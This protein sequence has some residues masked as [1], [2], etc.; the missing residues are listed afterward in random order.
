MAAPALRSHGAARPLRGGEFRQACQNLIRS[1]RGG[2][3]FRNEKPGPGRFRQFMQFDADTVGAAS[4]AADAEMCMMAADTLEALGIPRGNYIIK[5]NNRKVLDGVDGGDR[6]RRRRQSRPAAHGA[7]GHRQARPAR[8]RGV[9]QLLGEGRKDESGDFTKG[10]GLSECVGSA[11]VIGFTGLDAK[12][13]RIGAAS[14]ERD[15]AIANFWSSHRLGR[16]RRLPKVSLERGRWLALG[17]GCRLQDPRR[18]LTPP[19]CAAS[20]TIPAPSTRP[21]SPSR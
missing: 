21:S 12:A 14:G 10:A 2:W 3:V 9:R 11:G 8:R 5:V 19:S 20:N 13:I 18:R 16:R 7:A 17:R 4:V 6:P 15:A 1:F